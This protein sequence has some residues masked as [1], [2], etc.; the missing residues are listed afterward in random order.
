MLTR[1]LPNARD[2]IENFQPNNR[3]P[4]GKRRKI[5]LGLL[6]RIQQLHAEILDVTRATL[7]DQ[8]YMREAQEGSRFI[9][10][11]DDVL[12]DTGLKLEQNHLLHTL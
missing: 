10:E 6:E 2:E 8:D 7:E 4:L 3:K 9:K 11:L 1:A 5:L 12:Y